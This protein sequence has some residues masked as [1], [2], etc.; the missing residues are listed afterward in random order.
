M[1]KLLLSFVLTLSFSFV[2]SQSKELKMELDSITSIERAEKFISERKNK[3]NKIITFNQEKHKT[4]LAEDLF[5]KAKGSS[6]SIDGEFE[7]THYKVIEKNK[8]PYYRVQYILLDGTQLNMERINLLRS[9]MMR[10]LNQGVAFKDIAMRYSMDTNR[11]RGGDSGWITSGEML[12]EFESQV[13]HSDHA[14]G[15]VFLVD[16]KSNN[17]Y[18][19][20]M[21][22][23]D[24]KHIA[25][26]KVLKIVEP[27]RR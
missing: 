5:K 19:V 21:K 11:T 15:D 10:Q 27:K 13:M 2:F 9:G 20:V 25:E 7:K 14:I 16:V 26:I 4:R 24:M 8:I 6:K 23:H 18:Y 3:K 1:P 22:T 17:W 12:P